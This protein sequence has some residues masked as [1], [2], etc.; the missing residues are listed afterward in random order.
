MIRRDAF[1]QRGLLN[2]PG[3]LELIDA[4]L[5]DGADVMGGL[6]PSTYERDP[7]EH[8]DQVFGM[9]ERHQVGADI[10]LHEQGDIGWFTMDLDCSPRRIVIHDGRV[11]A[12]DGALV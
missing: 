5:R 4:A 9:C 11:V 2:D 8:L 7:V 6:D 10:H 12:I 1:P 3:A